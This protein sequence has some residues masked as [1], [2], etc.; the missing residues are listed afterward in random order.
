MVATAVATH[1][2]KSVM[3]SKIHVEQRYAHPRAKVWRA[4]TEPALM[5]KWGMRPEGF[6]A[7]ARA[8]GTGRMADTWV[9]DKRV[10]PDSTKR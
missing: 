8:G 2:K 7:V 10:R 1:N 3:Q 5:Q 9:S 4:I 6:A